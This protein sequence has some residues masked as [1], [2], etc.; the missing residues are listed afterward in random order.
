MTRHG[1]APGSG[2]A[3]PGAGEET[4]KTHIAKHTW[5]IPSC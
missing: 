1:R 3:G 4:S 2:F 5:R